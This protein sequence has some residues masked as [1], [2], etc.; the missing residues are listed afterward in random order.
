MNTKIIAARAEVLL[1][2]CKEQLPEL[3]APLAEA[4][5]LPPLT[6]EDHMRQRFAALPT[7]DF[8]QDVL[9][10]AAA[11]LRAYRIPAEANWLDLGTPDRAAVWAASPIAAREA[12]SAL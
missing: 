10:R 1:R 4:A 3:T 8:S 6:R 2:L 5:T 7:H 9:T 11:S 12:V